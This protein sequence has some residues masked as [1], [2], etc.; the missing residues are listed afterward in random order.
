MIPFFRSLSFYTTYL[1]AVF[2][3]GLF[4]FGFDAP[5]AHAVA[6]SQDGYRFYV[7]TNAITPTDPWPVGA[8]DIP[9]NTP[10]GVTYPTIGVDDVVRIRL[11][12][13]ASGGTYAAGNAFKL[14]YSTGTVCSAATGWTDVGGLSDT[15][16]AWRG[17]DNATPT[18][19]ATLPTTV[20]AASNVLETYEEANPSANT[21]NAILTA[22]VAEWD[23]VVQ[24]YAANADT[25]YC[26]RAV[27]QNGTVLETYTDY[28]KALTTAFEPKTFAWQWFSDE[29]HETP[30]STMSATST[31]ALGIRT[32]DPMKLRMTIG[33]A[34]ISKSRNQKFR[35]QFSTSTNFTQVQDVAEIADCVLG[36]LWCYADGVDTDGAVQT[37]RVL[38][39]STAVGTHN[40]TGTGASTFEHPTNGLVEY[41]FT[42]K[43]YGA[44]AETVYYFRAY[45]Q[46]NNA[47]LY[48]GQGGSFPSVKTF[49]TILTFSIE[50]VAAG[51][52]IAGVTTTVT[53]LTTSLPFGNLVLNTSAIGA[54][55]LRVSCDGTGYQAYVFV[56]RLLMNGLGE[57]IAAFPGTN[58][59]PSPWSEYRPTLNLRGVW[60]YHTTDAVLGGA[61]T[62]FAT[63]DTWAGIS[64]DSSE[65]AAFSLPVEDDTT[66]IVHRVEVSAVQFTGS[67]S[68]TIT[69]AVVATY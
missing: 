46:K 60:G 13:T 29:N 40:E 49:N 7:N 5:T 20:L 10:I 25:N 32:S 15:A 41:E 24:N 68:A 39:D 59:L 57:T 62:R 16:S 64:T 27:Y 63:A 55:R 6:L 9:E 37:T 21:P 47:L 4:C 50:G 30:T 22:Q 52:S 58:A 51:T 14:Q 31:K 2:G 8:T 3:I 69:Y 45:D 1:V 42:I 28:P 19:G 67:Y 23:W 18:D 66:T 33:A 26:F 35:L 53:T 61:S 34:T 12:I 65:I 38:G 44:V 36:S 11:N 54:H 43:R 56:D 17:Y 48:P